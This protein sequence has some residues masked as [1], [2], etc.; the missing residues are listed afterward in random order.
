MPRLTNPRQF[1]RDKTVVRTRDK[2]VEMV[3]QSHRGLKPALLRLRLAAWPAALREVSSPLC[4]TIIIATVLSLVRTTVLSL[5]CTAVSSL[6][7]TTD[8]SLVQSGAGQSSVA[9]TRS[10][11]RL[12]LAAWPTART[13]PQPCCPPV[14]LYLTQCIN[15]MISLKSIYPQTR[16][17]NLT[18][19]IV[20]DK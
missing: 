13:Q 15:Q 6:V 1:Y 5:V 2:T 18:Q 17:L 4:D 16:Q 8:L 19:G 3:R 9:S 12:R 7:R 10:S 14:R 11:S 20:T